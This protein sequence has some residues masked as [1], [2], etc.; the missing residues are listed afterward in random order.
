MEKESC[1]NNRAKSR[2]TVESSRKNRVEVTY[3]G[4]QL[5]GFQPIR[6][7]FITP[8]WRVC[9]FVLRPS[10]L[11]PS[12]GL[13][14]ISFLFSSSSSSSSSLQI[15][16]PSFPSTLAPSPSCPHIPLFVD[17]F[18]TIT[19]IL[20]SSQ[21]LLEKLSSSLSSLPIWSSFLVVL[22]LEAHLPPALSV[23]TTFRPPSSAT[24]TAPMRYDQS[25]K[26]EASTANR[27]TRKWKIRSQPTSPAPPTSCDLKQRHARMLMQRHILFGIAIGGV[28]VSYRNNLETFLH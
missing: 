20:I 4:V 8:Y 11:S 16:S 3:V 18:V 12:I 9:S 24:R 2:T 10:V 14:S 23:S 15:P 1:R 19:R 26:W 25:S 22:V 6:T 7:R 28:G 27:K 21:C 13:Y 17:L 5:L